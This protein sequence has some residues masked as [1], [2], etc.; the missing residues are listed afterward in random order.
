M[1]NK[2]ARNVKVLPS[3]LGAG[4]DLGFRNDLGDPDGTKAAG[5]VTPL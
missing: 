1:F 3:G 4:G 2:F 5:P